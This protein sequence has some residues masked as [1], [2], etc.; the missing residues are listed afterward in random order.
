MQMIAYVYAIWIWMIVSPCLIL[1]TH[2]YAYTCVTVDA[3]VCIYICDMDLD[4]CVA[5]SDAQCDCVSKY[6]RVKLAVK[7]HQVRTYIH[8][9]THSRVLCNTY[10]LRHT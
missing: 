6:A 4:N 3:C 9:Y 8:T 10:K 2:V 1:G 7:K 5:R